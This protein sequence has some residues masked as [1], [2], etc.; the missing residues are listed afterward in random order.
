MY[1]WTFL[2]FT[3]KENTQAVSRPYWSV[4]VYGRYFQFTR[5]R[6]FFALRPVNKINNLEINKR[7][8]F[9]VEERLL[10]L[11]DNLKLIYHTEKKIMRTKR[12]ANI[13][14]I[15]NNRF[16][17]EKEAAACWLKFVL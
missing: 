7:F 4:A 1:L 10:T 6:I 2:R 9:E 11:A 8:S 14:D 15:I 17:F 12:E 16:S 5:H 13:L 3:Y